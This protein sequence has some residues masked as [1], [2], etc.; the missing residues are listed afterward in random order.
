MLR[1]DHGGTATGAAR[2]VVLLDALGRAVRR[3]AVAA[4]A[5]TAALDVSGL[6]AG[7]YVVRCETAAGRLVVE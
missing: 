2:P 1:P 6:A 4:G 3:G 5:T 7:V